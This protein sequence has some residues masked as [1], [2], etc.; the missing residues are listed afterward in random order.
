MRKALIVGIDDYATAPLAGC[1]N[2]AIALAGCLSKHHDGSPNFDVRLLS[3]PPDQ[4]TRSVLRGYIEQLFEKPADVALLYFSGHGTENN[5]GGYLVTQDATRY[6]E[7]VA[8]TDVLTLA[9]RSRVREI[10]ILLDSCHSG[11]L[12]QLPAID[13]DY[14]NI[15]EGITILTASRSSEA[16]VETG[17]MGLFTSLVVAALEGGAADAIGRVTVASVYDYVE[18]TLGPWD[19]RPLFK[20]HISTLVSLR[21]AQP[22]IDVAILRKLPEWFPRPD[23]E[24]SLDPSYE[25]DAEPANDEHEKVFGC[26]QKCR[27]AKLV[28][29]V[30]EEHMYFAAMNSKSC[31]LTPLGRHYWR[32]ANEGRI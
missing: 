13:N 17:G 9:N 23:G 7:G 20:A 8:L 14:A 24:F 26:L 31:R 15:R 30:G 1:V 11:A 22:A 32:L 18:E 12:G 16:A 21:N 25:P 4:I 6:D 3:A 10:V 29:P 28:E 19:Q 27:A 5:L 2:D